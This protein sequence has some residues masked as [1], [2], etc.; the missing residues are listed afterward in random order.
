[1][2]KKSTLTAENIQAQVNVEPEKKGLYGKIFFEWEIPESIKHERSFLWYLAMIIL[3]AAL[4]VYCI[5]TANFLFALVIILAIF[6]AFLKN[7]AP[8]RDIK[9]QIVEDGVLIG[10]QLFK[11]NRIK[12]FYFIYDPPAVKKLFF[13]IKGLYPT[14][15]VP[16][17][18][19]NPLVIR[20]K[21]LEYLKEDLEKEH[22]TLD[23]Q[24][25]T[26]LKL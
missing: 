3:A 18:D 14:I 19:M 7:F 11:Y 15:S 24:L 26:L 8:A 22:Q 23:D 9:F 16:L 17:H 6:I 5:I 13:S 12:N 1:M 25:E 4:V 20:K 21:L 2:D 10:N